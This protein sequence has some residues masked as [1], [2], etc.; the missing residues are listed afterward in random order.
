V[1]E[2]SIKPSWRRTVKIDISRIRRL[3]F[4][5]YV[6]PDGF[7][8]A[9]QPLPV[10]GYLIEHPAGRILFDTGFSPIDEATRQRFMPRARPVEEALNAVGLTPSDVDMIANCHLHPDHA[11]GNS[12]F[13][14]VPVYVQE[15]ELRLGR[16]PDHTF[17]EFSFDYP[18][19]RLEVVSGETE[20][21]PGVRLVPTPGHTA[22]HQAMVVDTDIGPVLLAGQVFNTASEFGHAAF[23]HRL[24]RDGLDS[25]GAFPEW[26]SWFDTLNPARTFFAHD[27]L[28][29][30]RDEA[31]RGKATRI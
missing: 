25:V 1:V 12:R 11:G 7:L 22:G 9:G 15:A 8:D 18:G 4:G 5:Y 27:V 2:N 16:E 13:P 10:C 21:L 6:I 28:V 31:D 24:D 23:A 26:M 20:I 3:H 30:E 29:F 14:G 17:P 19:A